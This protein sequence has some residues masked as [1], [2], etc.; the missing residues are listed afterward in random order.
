MRA[1]LFQDHRQKEKLGA[2]APWSVG[3]I[4]P[5]GKRKSKRIGSKSQAGKFR[6]KIEGQLAAGTYQSPSSKQWPQF[7][8]D[9]EQRILQRQAVRSREPTLT[10]F[11]H[12]ERISKPRKMT[13][14]TTKTIDEFIARRQQDRGKKKNSTVSPATVNRDLRHLKAALGVAHDWGYLP[15]VPKFRMLREADEIGQVM[16]PEHFELIYNGSGAATK[17]D[18]LGCDPATWWQGLLLFALTTGWRIEEILTFGRDDLNLDTGEIITRAGH[19]KGKRDDIDHLPETTLAHV[20]LVVGFAPTV[21]YWPHDR[22]TLDAEFH[23]IQESVGIDLVCPK[24]DEHECTDAC[25]RYGFHSLRRAY[26][27]LNVDTMPGPVLQKKM[28]HRSFQTTLRYIKLADKMKK[29]T[30]QVFVPEFL[31]DRKAN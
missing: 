16:T 27:T 20:R 31:Q 30:E 17:P 28:R 5:D 14:I 19:N 11:K 15:T 13:A 21:F 29:T 1:W 23:S 6:R 2:K 7:R 25:H 24:A 22:R 10:A 26:A 3:W 12:F 4:D 18:G 8:E 9:Y